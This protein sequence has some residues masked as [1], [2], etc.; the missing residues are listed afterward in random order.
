MS[1]DIAIVM[2]PARTA[3]S[4][5]AIVDG[6]A[7]ESSFHQHYVAILPDVGRRAQPILGEARDA[8]RARTVDRADAGRVL[9]HRRVGRLDV[10]TT[11]PFAGIVDSFRDDVSRV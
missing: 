6:V 11:Q 5:A 8:G 9:A 4:I 3:P 1:Q 7:I 10:D 2:P